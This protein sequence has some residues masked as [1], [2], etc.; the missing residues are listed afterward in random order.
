MLQTF[1]K[2]TE[3][4]RQGATFLF[5]VGFLTSV[6]CLVSCGKGIDEFRNSTNEIHVFQDVSEFSKARYIEGSQASEIIIHDLASG[7]ATWWYAADGSAESAP[8]TTSTSWVSAPAGPAG[9]TLD[10]IEAILD[11]SGNYYFAAVDRG[12]RDVYYGYGSSTTVAWRNVYPGFD[13]VGLQLDLLLDQLGQP[14]IMFANTTSQ[15]VQ[16]LQGSAKG[17]VFRLHEIAKG[18]GRFLAAGVDPANTVYCAWADNNKVAL[19][20]YVDGAWTQASIWSGRASS[21]AFS[22]GPDDQDDLFVAFPRVTWFDDEQ[23]DL[24][25]AARIAGTW[26]Q[27][28]IQ[29]AGTA[30]GQLRMSVHA[31]GTVWLSYLDRD[32]LDLW[33]SRQDRNGNWYSTLLDD[34][35]ATGLWP[36]VTIN[37]SGKTLLLFYSK[38][39]QAVVLREWGAL[40]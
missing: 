33:G 26:E 15:T 4:R 20:A 27:Q 16:A 30:G 31:E 38:Q 37:K 22:I 8:E 13:V 36:D 28:L 25:Y 7:Y 34:N 40:L 11:A 35:G 5:L 29:S 2:Q 6:L 10:A 1:E 21:L 19:S 14:W 3:L 18:N 32:L 39:R 12:N 17:Q 9:V 23:G 24:W